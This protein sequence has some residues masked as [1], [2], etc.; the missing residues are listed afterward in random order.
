MTTI[1]GYISDGI[2]RVYQSL[3][4]YTVETVGQQVYQIDGNSPRN[5][6]KTLK[7]ARVS[8]IDLCRPFVLR[9]QA[10]QFS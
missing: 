9:I 1:L 5:Q 4:P 7:N 8:I 10:L 2:T 6:L 3:A